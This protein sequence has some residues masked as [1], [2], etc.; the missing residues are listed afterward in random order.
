MILQLLAAAAVATAAAPPEPS[1]DSHTVVVR[2]T[3]PTGGTVEVHGDDTAGGDF[4]AVWPATAYSARTDGDV[5][6]SCQIDVF[7]LAES[8]QVLSES[9]RNKGFGHA[10]L[11]LR[12]TFR[13]KPAPDGPATRTLSFDLHFKAPDPQW[14]FGGDPHRVIGGPLAMRNVT[15]L[16]NPVWA[17]AASYDDMVRAYPPKAGKLD[18]YA[19]VH[20]MVLRGGALNGCQI[21]KEDPGKLGFG[22]A[23]VTLA[24]Q[25]RVAP[26][27]L[28]KHYTSSLWVDVPIR[29]FAPGSA[30]ERTVVSPVWMAGMDPGRAPKVYPPEAAAAGVTSGRGVAR[31]TVGADGSLTNCAPETAEPPGLGFSEAAVKLASTM[32]MAPWSADAAPVDGATV[33]VGI[34]L[35][36]K[37]K[38]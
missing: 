30:A 2:P 15:M 5:K 10:A 14:G 8:C 25:F 17:Q 12:P 3:P 13:L 23:A 37:G 32:K 9:P 26:E 1:A 11:E 36:L 29:F 33:R 21:I 24:R 38:P 34:R 31:C 4:V 27:T 19:A 6:L 35:N 22:A 20:C 7:G 18:G 28:A 16:D